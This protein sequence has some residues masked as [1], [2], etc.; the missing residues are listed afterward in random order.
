MDNNFNFR[1]EYI[2]AL[3]S[4]GKN[5][6]AGLATMGLIGAGIGIGFIF[7]SFIH[8][9]SNNKEFE[10]PGFKFVMLGFALCEAVGLLSVVMAF[11]IL[12][13]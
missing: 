6:G 1:E 7:A 13:G 10:K 5:I 12:Y 3:I 4:I 2:H 11:L 8:A 9:Y